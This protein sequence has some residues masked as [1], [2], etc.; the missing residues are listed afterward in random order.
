MC[1]ARLLTDRPE[2]GTEC[3]AQP[4]RLARLRSVDA[5]LHKMRGNL[6]AARRP[7]QTRDGNRYA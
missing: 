1:V 4:T 2:L 6:K 5:N 3:C 7:V